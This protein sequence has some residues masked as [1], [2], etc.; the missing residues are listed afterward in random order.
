MTLEIQDLY[1]RLRTVDDG[2]RGKERQEY[3]N[4]ETVTQV[5]VTGGKL[6][7]LSVS[8]KRTSPATRETRETNLVG[9]RV[10]DR[11]SVV[12]ER[13]SHGIYG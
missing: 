5:G 11:S 4:G 10:R 7:D 13:S 8:G 6:R 1:W 2:T 3:R 12:E 9:G